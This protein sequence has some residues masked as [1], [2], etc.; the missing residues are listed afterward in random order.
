MAKLDGSHDGMVTQK[1]IKELL[2]TAT[3]N[4]TALSLFSGIG[5]LCAGVKKAGFRV[6]GAVE[7]DKYAAVNYRLNFPEIPLYDGS[8]A[9]FLPAETP[10]VFEQHRQTYANTETLDLLF[11]GPPCQGYSQIGPRDVADPRNEMYLEM[12]RLATLLHPKFILIENVPNMLLMKKGMFKERI[13]NSLKSIGYSNIGLKVL[14]A[15]DFGVPQAR[16]RVFIL[17]TKPE[18]LSQNLQEIFDATAEALVEAPVSVDDAISDLPEEVTTNNTDPI[19]YPKCSA[20]TYFQ[21]EMRLDTDGDIFT[22]E[23][24]AA[25]YKKITG[26]AVNGQSL[27]NHHTKEIQ[28]RRLALIKLLKPGKKADSL[29]KDVWDNARPEKWRRFDGA[30][31]A[32]TLLAQMHRDLSEWIHPK[33]DRFI[34][35][36]E[37]MRLQTFPDSFVLQTSEWQQLKQIGN[38]V[39]PML[40]RIPASVIHVALAMAASAKPMRI[41]KSQMSLFD[42]TI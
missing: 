2:T 34:T 15:V 10:E 29:P 8:V 4:Y 23:E 13:L 37:A 27:Y 31:P 26:K 21:R 24:K 11:G 17:A 6:V 41:Q 28:A 22:K 30:L 38:A 20:P 42:A 16:R 32:H 9:G 14:N 33:H 12:I 3:S 36:R 25:T 35:V 19:L 18:T 5:G 40:G 7:Y 39:P 1:W